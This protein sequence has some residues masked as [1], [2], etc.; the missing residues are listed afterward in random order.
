MIAI[1]KRNAKSISKII[2][3]DLA[4]I[5]NKSYKSGPQQKAVLLGGIFYSGA[6]KYRFF[7]DTTALSVKM[8][9][10]NTDSE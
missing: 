1:S 3:I 5:C 10:I 9:L 8:D 2:D 7:S 4:P 6:G